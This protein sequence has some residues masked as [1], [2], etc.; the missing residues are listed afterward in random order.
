M[1]VKKFSFKDKNQIWRLHISESDNDK[2]IIETR[3]MNTEKKEIFF[4]CLDLQTGRT[5]FKDLQFD[6][7]SWIGIETIHNDVII[8]HKYA[9][10]N[11]PGHKSVIGYDIVDKK[12]LWQHDEFTFRF[13]LNGKV[14]VSI[15]TIGGEK[16]YA[17][18]YI[19]GKIENP[20]GVKDSEVQRLSHL[21][22]KDYSSYKFPEIFKSDKGKKNE[23][24]QLIINETKNFKIS[25]NIEF[26]NLSKLFLL[27]YHYLNED[28]KV[29]NLF[30]AL[31]KMKNKV[32]FTQV[33]NKSTQAYVP[34]SFFI[35]KHLLL[36]FREKKKVEVFEIK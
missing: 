12:I 6:E 11:M 24:S 25:G 15:Y 14:Y 36:L 26:I 22:E 16:F 34:D 5:I 1:I 2:L 10:P 30:K 32:I 20:E 4:H 28:N 9:N 3:E 13:L 33:L 29:T 8:L 21:V 17:I 23:I 27:N 35:Y 18:D 19:T 31:D 7:K